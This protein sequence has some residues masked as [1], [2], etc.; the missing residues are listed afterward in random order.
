[1]KHKFAD[2]TYQAETDWSE[3]CTN[4]LLLL[5]LYV[6]IMFEMSAS[7]SSMKLTDN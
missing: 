3:M 2:K 4:M 1:M 7:L 5:I 6:V